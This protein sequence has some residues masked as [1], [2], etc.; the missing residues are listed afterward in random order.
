[1]NEVSLGPAL[2]VIQVLDELDVP[3]QVGGSFASSIHGTPRHT[4]D[5]D[6]VIDLPARSIP[7]FVLRLSR[8]FYV[9]EESVRSAV[10]RRSSFNLIHLETA[11]KVDCFQKGDGSFDTSEMDR[12][13]PVVLAAENRTVQA[14]SPEDT[15]LR[16]LLWYR[17][18]GQV[19]STQWQDVLGLVRA[20]G[21]RLDR[22]YLLRWARELGLQELLEK[23]LL[24]SV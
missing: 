21:E 3:Y 16:K 1:M 17:D 18:G 10:R 4:R 24:R 14:K 13:V 9:D 22:E 19:S 15:V 20:Q 2:Q 6:L 23:A 11:F 8:D 12:S 7:S 5:I